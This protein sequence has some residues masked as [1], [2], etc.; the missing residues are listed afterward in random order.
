MDGFQSK[1]AARQPHADVVGCDREQRAGPRHAGHRSDRGS[2]ARGL[3][4]RADAEH[5]GGTAVQD[6]PVVDAF[7]LEER[8]PALFAHG[9][10]LGDRRVAGR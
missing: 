6:D 9:A 2:E 7:G 3:L 10:L 4:E 8:L 5:S 1:D